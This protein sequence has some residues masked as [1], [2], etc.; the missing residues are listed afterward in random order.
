MT[1]KVL[2]FELLLIAAVSVAIVTMYPHLPE[3]VATHWDINLHPNGYSPKWMLFVLGPGI[4]AGISLFAWIGPSLSPERFQ[5]DSFRS[6]YTQ[7]MLMLSCAMAYLSG[8]ILWAAAGHRIDEGRAVFGGICVLFALMGNVMGKVRRNFFIGIK[9]P[10]T[11]GSERIWIATHRFAAKTFVAGGLLGLALT[12][13]G[14]RRWP[15]FALLAGALAPTIYSLVRYKQ[16]QRRG[17][18]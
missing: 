1:R 15:I 3:R 13:I 11:L 16:L 2:L 7:V 6:T 9:T 14:L 8:I 10:W 18:L 5:V 12:M 4:M 17:D